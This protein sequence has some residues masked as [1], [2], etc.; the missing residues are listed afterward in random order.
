MRAARRAAVV[1][2]VAAVWLAVSAVGAG[3]ITGLTLH[4]CFGTGAGCT[5]VAG[6]PLQGAQAIAVSRNGSV[7]V[8]GYTT[9][10]TVDVG[11]VSHFF[12]GKAGAFSY[13]ACVSDDGDDGACIDTP[14]PSSIL[15]F[16]DGIA[17]SPNGR[18]VY[19]SDYYGTLTHFFANATTGQLTWD[20]CVSA[21]GSGESCARAITSGS[22]DPFDAIGGVAV[23]PNASASNGS[24]FF[25][26]HL[27]AVSHLFARAV[28]GQLT[29]DRCL[30]D[31]GSEGTCM[32]IPGAGLPL[33]GAGGIAV[34]PRGTA[35]YVATADSA[36]GV[37]QLAASPPDGGGFTS[38][39]GCL[40]AD[41]ENGCSQMPAT[42]DSPLYG[43]NGIVV[44]PNGASVYVASELSDSVS[45]FVADPA[46]KKLL[47]WQGCISDDGTG[48][49]CKRVPSRGTPLE[50]VDELA[51]SP[52]GKTVYAVSAAASSLS[53][54][55]VGSQGQLTFEGCLADDPTPGCTNPPGAPLREADSVAV[56]PD[57]STVY[58]A[59]ALGTV[60]SFVVKTPPKPPKPKLTLTYSPK[61]LHAGKRTTVTF[62][63]MSKGKPVHRAQVK[64]AGR[65]GLT[66]SGGYVPFTLVLQDRTYTAT[67]SATGKKPTSITLHPR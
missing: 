58:V 41:N 63:V 5:N 8:T 56:S 45:H 46:G 3:A 55:G 22:G 48:G 15:G 29:Y 28:Q 66:G 42:A 12:A 27:G 57:S 13:D 31:D 7:Y 17:V 53:W 64:F 6:N 67:A 52:D 54:F 62:R 24:V 35:V 18:S 34:N 4:K 9:I 10:G 32:D 61:P 26:S 59:G 50:L 65:T 25:I 11:S 47:R 21:D 16:A 40:N 14:A 36:G 60:A 1:G 39:I 38:F 44:S 2:I 51:I 30:S 19:V 43:A 33:E 20:G 23:S 37:A 49:E